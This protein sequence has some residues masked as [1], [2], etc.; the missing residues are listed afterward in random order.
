MKQI[1]IFLLV[2]ILGIIGYNLYNKYQRF[3]L[4]NYEYKI[5][6]DIDIN[7]ADRGDLLN[8]Y[9]AI[10]AANGYLITQWSANSIDVRNPIN[11][12]ETTVAAVNEYRKKLAAVGYYEALVKNPK[13]EEV[14]APP[15][16][17]ERK[18]ELIKK[19]FKDN[20]NSIRLGEGSPMVYEIQRLLIDKGY[21]IEHDGLFKNQTFNALKSF[22]EKH[23]LFVDGKL[24]AITLSILLD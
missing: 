23:G 12:R 19:M 20:P 17:L 16:K 13:K 3:S 7:N 21:Q 14:E 11:D 1:I 15:S 10:E 9:E 24:D 6:S 8:Y 5:P 18:K 2:I 4:E 22:E